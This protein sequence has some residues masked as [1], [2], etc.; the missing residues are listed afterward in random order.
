M[1]FGFYKKAT[2]MSKNPFF[3]TPEFY[4]NLFAA[5]AILQ[6]PN[7]HSSSS[8]A[9]LSDNGSSKIIDAQNFARNL[10]FS[11]NDEKEVFYLKIM[12]LLFNAN[13]Q[14]VENFTFFLNFN[15]FS[16]KL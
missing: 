13:M 5:S 6:K 14:E 7:A 1:G 10:F 2:N 9:A 15:F 11:C 16:R 4:K 8:A 12:R 3:L